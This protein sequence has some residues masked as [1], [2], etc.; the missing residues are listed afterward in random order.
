MHFSAPIRHPDRGSGLL[1]LGGWR[2]VLLLFLGALG[3]T[4]VD[5]LLATLL[6]KLIRRAVSK[7]YKLHA[8]PR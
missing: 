5:W 4:V 6:G 2:P 8:I 3:I 1:K 7:L